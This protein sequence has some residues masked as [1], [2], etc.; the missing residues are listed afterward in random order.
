MS[1]ETLPTLRY[2]LDQAAQILN[3]TRATLY[4]RIKD[5]ELTVHRDGRRVYVTTAELQRYLAAKAAFLP[6]AT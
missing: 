5:G 6:H 1:L 4:T 2:S 3:F